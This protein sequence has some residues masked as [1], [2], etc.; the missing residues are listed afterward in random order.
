MCNLCGE[1][2]ESSEHVLNCS[3]IEGESISQDKLKDS[4]DLTSWSQ[5]CLRF[6]NFKKAKEKQE[7]DQVIDEKNGEDLSQ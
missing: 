3:Q 2:E 4:K 7:L 6:R 1:E 5:I